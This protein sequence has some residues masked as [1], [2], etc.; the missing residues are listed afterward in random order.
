MRRRRIGQEAM[1][2]ARQVQ[3][4]QDVGDF[5]AGE[6][7]VGDEAPE[8]LTQSLAL[9]GNDGGVGNW[10]AQTGG[11]TAPSRRTNPRCRR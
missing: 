8:R 4:R 6:D 5:V 3:P 10:Y 2:D 9:V 11:E 7:V 1:H